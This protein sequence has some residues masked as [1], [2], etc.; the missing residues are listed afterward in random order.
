LLTLPRVWGNAGPGRRNRPAAVRPSEKLG[1]SLEVSEL[2]SGAD[3]VASEP[4][5]ANHIRDAERGGSVNFLHNQLSRFTL[6]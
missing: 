3:G 1:A 5:V 2:T 6:R 4:K